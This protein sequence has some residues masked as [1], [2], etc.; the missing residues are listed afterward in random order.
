MQVVLSRFE[1]HGVFGD[2]S[3]PLIGS[4]MGPLASSAMTVTSVYRVLV[5]LVLFVA[6]TARPLVFA[7]VASRF[8]QLGSLETTTTHLHVPAV[9]LP[10]PLGLE[11][12][13]LLVLGQTVRGTAL[14]LVVFVVLVGLDVAHRYGVV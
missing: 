10:G 12:I 7:D 9:T 1:V 11:A 2:D 3:G 13:L 5:D 6:E 4:S 14:P 8:L